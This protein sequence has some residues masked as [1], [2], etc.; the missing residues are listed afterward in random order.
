MDAKPEGTFQRAVQS[1]LK[2]A[3]TRGQGG[4]STPGR[5]ELGHG[6]HA[7]EALPSSTFLTWSNSGWLAAVCST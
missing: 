7:P 6:R 1:L 3:S 2:G 5:S 4:S